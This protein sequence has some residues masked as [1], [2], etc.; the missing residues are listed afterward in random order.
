MFGLTLPLLQQGSRWLSAGGVMLK[1]KRKKTYSVTTFIDAHAEIEGVVTFEGTIRIDG[2]IRGKISSR[3]GTLI[4]G[5][6]AVINA[7]IAVDV[8]IL[9]GEINGT[10][11]A[12]QRIEAYP[13]CR[14]TGDIQAPVISIASGVEFN[15]HCTMASDNVMA[16]RPGESTDRIV[17]GKS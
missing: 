13:P 12:S 17:V 4:V 5:E 3:S 7:E 11:T 2:N 6:K 10:I 15:G 1:K 8:A 16:I 14:V 9:M